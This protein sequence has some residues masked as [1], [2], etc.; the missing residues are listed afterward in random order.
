MTAF[1][2][3]LV[4]KPGKETEFEKLQTELSKLTHENEPETL[5]YDVLRHRERKDTY[6]VYARF[7]N[8]DA[9]QTHQATDFHERLV[10]PIV[11]CLA[12]DFEIDFYDFIA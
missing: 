11:D 4:V 6:V 1:I 12:R 8:E 3:T 7:R 2:A 10:P 5:V 9:F